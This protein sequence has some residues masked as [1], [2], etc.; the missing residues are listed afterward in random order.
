MSYLTIFKYISLD[1][2]LVIFAINMFFFVYI[3]QKT[4]KAKAM[5]KTI[6]AHFTSEPPFGCAEQNSLPYYLRG[7]RLRRCQLPPVMVN[8]EPTFG[9]NPRCRSNIDCSTSTHPNALNSTYPSRRKIYT[10][11]L[12]TVGPTSETLAQQQPNIG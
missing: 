3:K 6:T 2:F 4:G 7:A 11:C 10:Q 8:V 9:L 12:V 1:Y 5:E